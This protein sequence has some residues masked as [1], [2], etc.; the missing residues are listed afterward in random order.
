MNPF[1]LLADVILWV[2]YALVMAALAAVLFSWC[3]SLRMRGGTKGSNGVPQT[4]IKAVAVSHLK[5][6]RVPHVLATEQE[7]IR[8]AERYGEDVTKARIAALLHD[9][10]KKLDMEEQMALCRKYD[11]PL[12]ELEQRALKLLHAKT[13]AAI[14]RDV[15]G[16][17]DDIY[18]AI[19]WHT[20]GH[21][22][23]TR[24]EKII[25]LADYIEATRDFPGVEELR[26]V[27]YEEGLDAGMVL[28]LSMTVEEM[29]ARGN[30]VHSATLAALADLKGTREI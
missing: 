1:A 16:V 11:I 17:D 18:T 19:F 24:L 22:H 8:L 12:D 30:P 4:G 7:A 21:A 2:V 3:R 15:Y 6:K 29:K 13:G 5:Y 28:G 14:A 20:T 9:T 10:T 25:Y 23:M 27:C 26:R